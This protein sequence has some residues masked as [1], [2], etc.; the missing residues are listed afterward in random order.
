MELRLRD[1]ENA[2]ALRARADALAKA[3]SN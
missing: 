3:T 1:G 2:D